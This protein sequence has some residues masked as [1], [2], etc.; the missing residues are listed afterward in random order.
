MKACKIDS[1]RVSQYEG[2]RVVDIVIPVEKPKKGAK[3]IL[4]YSPMLQAN[5]LVYRNDLKPI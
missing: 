1:D 4:V 5:V 2:T 3:K